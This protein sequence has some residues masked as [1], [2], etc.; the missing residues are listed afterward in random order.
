[1]DEDPDGK[2]PWIETSLWGGGCD[3]LY[4]CLDHPTLKPA[5]SDLHYTV[6]A[7]LMAPGNG[8]LVSKID[9]DG[10]TTWNWH[11]R[12][13]HSYGS[14]LNVGPYKVMEGDYQSRFGNTIPM[15]FYYLPGEEQPAEELFAEFPQALDFFEA[16]IGP[17]PWP[18]QKMGAIRVPY[19][20]LEN[21]TLIGYSDPYPKTAFGWDS[22]LYHELSHEWFANQVSVANYDDLG[23]TRA[24][25]P[26]RSRSSR[27]IW[28]ARSTTWRS[29][30]HSAPAS[31]TTSHS[32]PER[33]DRRRRSMP[34]PPVR[35][36]TSIRK[37]AGWPTRCAS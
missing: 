13:V 15:R 28:A 29:S 30:S 9:K 5:T 27:S 7:G 4:P 14:V 1:M 33:S 6:P 17:Y 37:G 21:Q 34:N 26:T 20:G 2:Y 19:S 18:D 25:A 11:A 12:S 36:A 32:S 10:W 31:A 3:L 8:A 22:L 23:S 35:V 24:S 16:V